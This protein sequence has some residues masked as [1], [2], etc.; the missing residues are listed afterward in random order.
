MELQSNSS[1][2][3]T[4]QIGSSAR[5]AQADWR[6]DLSKI[7]MCLKSNQLASA[8]LLPSLD[9]AILKIETLLFHDQKV[10]QEQSDKYK[11]LKR[12]V[13]DYQKYVNDKLA[14][15]KAERQRSEDYC[16]MV[17][18][19]LLARV[20]HELELLEENRV[21]FNQPSNNVDRPANKVRP[22]SSTPVNPVGI[23][24][25]PGG[26]TFAQG[27]DDLQQQVN[28]YIRGLTN[29]NK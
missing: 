4:S 24:P 9:N 29:F 3:Q 14:K 28:M 5:S 6:L 20:T 23:H 17:I 27:I 22:S 15:N 2:P 21:N 10:I 18:S 13:R 25:P 26:S 8:D 12:R 19:D 1:T 11:Q 16:R 7:K